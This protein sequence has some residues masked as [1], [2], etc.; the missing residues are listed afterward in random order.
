MG[1]ECSLRLEPPKKA[2]I[3][4]KRGFGFFPQFPFYLRLQFVFLLLTRPLSLPWLPFSPFVAC[5]NYLVLCLLKMHLNVT[6]FPSSSCSVNMELKGRGWRHPLGLA[7]SQP[8]P[9]P[10][11]QALRASFAASA[12]RDPSEQETWLAGSH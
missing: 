1:L 2:L 12:I 4:A 6:S 8:G 10:S 3:Q 5:K 9:F 7:L 11:S